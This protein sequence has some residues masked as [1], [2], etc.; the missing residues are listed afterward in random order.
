MGRNLRTHEGQTHDDGTRPG[1]TGTG[2]EEG[3]HPL[4]VSR[5]DR[6]GHP[7]HHRGLPVPRVRGGAQAAR[8]GL[9]RADQDDDPAGHLLH[10]RA[11][12]RVGAQRR[13]GR[14]GRRPRARLLPDHVHGGTGDRPGRGQH[15][16]ARRGPPAQRR[17]RRRGQGA[18][19]RRQRE[20]HRLRARDRPRLAVLRRH[21]RRDPADPARRPARRLRPADDGPSRGP[22]D[23]RHR[24]PAARGLPGAGDDHVGRPGRRVRRHR[25]RRRRDRRRRPAE[26]RRDH[27][28][29]LR[30]LRGLRVHHPR[31]GAQARHRRE[32]VQAAALPRTRV[33]ADPVD[34][35]LGVGPAAAD[36]ED[37]ARRHRQDD[38]GRRGPDR[39]LLQPRRHRDL[40]DH[41][42]AV[43]RLRAR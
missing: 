16:Q 2:D 6:R 13:P 10:D 28:R 29:L 18:G 42:V 30:D 1:S 37:G 35:V 8:R 32:P 22:G 34:L 21:L 39:V 31:R 38:R 14:Q 9:R 23:P 3:P 15:P 33:P 26:P 43:H 17:G 7:R 40:P 11:R 27:V 20:H 5:G 4:P 12:R 19:G 41:G 25:R 36:R 24:A